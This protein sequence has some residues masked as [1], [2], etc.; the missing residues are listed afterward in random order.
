MINPTQNIG[1]RIGELGADRKFYGSAFALWKR[2]R[3]AQPRSR[4]P[5]HWRGGWR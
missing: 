2:I 4:I 1:D 3:E 5:L